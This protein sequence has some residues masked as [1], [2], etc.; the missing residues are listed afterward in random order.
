M[1]DDGSY[2]QRPFALPPGATEIVFVRHGASANATPGTP[3]PMVAGRGDPPL[4]SAGRAQARAVGERLKG[5]PLT[6][7]F[8][9]PLRRTHETAAPLAEATG[10]EPVVIDE[11]IEVSLGEWEGGEFRIRAA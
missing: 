6:K 1:T 7:L 3:F 10:L 11:L 4:A 8:V 5:E 9:T 2:S